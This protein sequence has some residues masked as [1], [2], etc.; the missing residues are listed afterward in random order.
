M[1]RVFQ[2]PPKT[3][4]SVEIERELVEFVKFFRLDDKLTMKLLMEHYP[5]V[6]HKLAEGLSSLT[7]SPR[8]LW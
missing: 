1:P 6:G 3:F 8:L 2:V 4:L 7:K 5:D